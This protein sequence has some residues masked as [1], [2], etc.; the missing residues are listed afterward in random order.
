VQTQPALAQVGVL[1]SGKALRPGTVVLRSNLAESEAARAIGLA[2]GMAKLV[3]D[4]RG[5]MLG[6]GALGAGSAE[7][8]SLLALAM[9][10]RHSVAGLGQLALP[11]P[12]IAAL[13][14]DLAEQYIARQPQARWTRRL[15]MLGRLLP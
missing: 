9:N 14:I 15:P 12:S 5:I 8:M 6:G 10:R 1:E 11:Q 13:L 2:R 7:T 3:V 4:R